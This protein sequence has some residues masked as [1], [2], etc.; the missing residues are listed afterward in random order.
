MQHASLSRY[1]ISC[2]SS[3][4]VFVVSF[5][6]FLA[7]RALVLVSVLVLVLVWCIVKIPMATLSGCFITR[8][9]IPLSQSWRHAPMTK[10]TVSFL[11]VP[12]HGGFTVFSECSKTCGGGTRIR[13]C[14]NPEPR[15]GGRG[16]VGASQ[17]TCNTKACEST[18]FRVQA[19]FLSFFL[20][21]VLV[22]VCLDGIHSW[23]YLLL[24]LCQFRCMAGFRPSADALKRVVAELGSE[25]ALIPSLKMAAGDVQ[26]HRRKHATRK[27]A[28]VRNYYI[29][30]RSS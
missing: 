1:K 2:P 19:V 27:P 7:V 14:T 8:F 22:L 30:P 20:L 9:V 18:T 11:L 25:L 15:N 10:I 4:S 16:C 12:V 5:L 17:E 21:S 26:A 6:F 28:K 3:L 13:T 29:G 24:H 23:T